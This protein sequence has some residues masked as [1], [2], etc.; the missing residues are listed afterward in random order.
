MLHINAAVSY[1]LLYR[2][3][4]VRTERNTTL[5]HSFKQNRT[6]L[7][8]YSSS[9]LLSYSGSGGVRSSYSS[10][11]LRLHSKVAE[12]LLSLAPVHWRRSLLVAAGEYLLSGLGSSG[13]QTQAAVD[14]RV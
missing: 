1:F 9:F 2:Y 13:A 12:D 3:Y 14:E 8:Y 11:L 6:E 5:Q 4:K 10:F 7:E